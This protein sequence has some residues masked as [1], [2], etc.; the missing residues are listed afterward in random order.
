MNVKTCLESCVLHTYMGTFHGFIVQAD[1][2]L[3]KYLIS[4]MSRVYIHESFVI[5]KIF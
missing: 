4:A 2:V 3:C 1:T 5:E